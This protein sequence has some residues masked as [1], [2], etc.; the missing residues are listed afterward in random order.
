[1][2]HRSSYIPPRRAV[3][4]WHGALTSA[5]SAFYNQALVRAFLLTLAPFLVSPSSLHQNLWTSLA[6][7]KF[8]GRIIFPRFCANG[9]SSGLIPPPCFP[10]P[11]VVGIRLVAEHV[12]VDGS[13]LYEWVKATPEDSMLVLCVLDLSSNLLSGGVLSQITAFVVCREE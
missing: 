5:T 13:K 9:Q 7:N 10:C 6:V 4:S 8:R 11:R 12:S 1:M 2:T 3:T